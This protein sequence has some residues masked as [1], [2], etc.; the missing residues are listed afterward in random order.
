[1][2]GIDAGALAWARSAS[3]AGAAGPSEAGSKRGST[4]T[5]CRSAPQASGPRAPGARTA[6]QAGL[7]AGVDRPGHGPEQ[8]IELGRHGAARALAPAPRARPSV[9]RPRR[10]GSSAR[11]ASRGCGGCQAI[12]RGRQAG[13]P[14]GRGGRGPAKN[15]SPASDSTAA[16]CRAS[17]RS[18][19]ARAAAACSAR[20]GVAPSMT[21]TI[22]S[23]NSG[24]ARDEGEVVLAEGDLGRDHV[25]G[26]G[27]DAQM[28]KA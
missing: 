24:N 4:S 9:A 20:S 17:A 1:M 23:R 16:K 8:P 22:G 21:A 11:A 19:S 15:G 3:I 13:R 2:R 5:S 12:G 27:V 26:A 10:L 18:D 28:R 25:L 7:R 14:R 6:H